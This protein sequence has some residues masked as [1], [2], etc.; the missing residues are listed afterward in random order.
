[1]TTLRD[2]PEIAALGRRASGADSA[3]DRRAAHAARA[4]A[5]RH[6][7]VSPAARDQPAG[8]GV[9]RLSGGQSHAVRALAGR[10]S[11]GAVVSSTG[12][13]TTSGSPRR[14]RRG[15]PSG[16]WW[17][18]CCTTWGTGRS[19]IRSK[20][21][22]CRR[23]PTHELFA[24]S[25]LLEGEIADAAARRL[26]PPAARR[27]RAALRQARDRSGRIL[28]SM[29][30]GPIDVDKMDY[31]M[32][33][34]LH[35]GVPYGRNFDQPRLIDSLCLNEAGD[36]AGDHRQGQDGRR[37][38]GL[39]PLRDVQRSLLASRRAVGHGDAAAGVFAR[40]TIARSRRPVSPDR[41][42]D[43]RR[44]ARRGGRRP[45]RRTARRTVRPDAAALQAGRPVQLVPTAG[46]LPAAGPPAVSVAGS[47]RRA[48]RDASASTALARVVAP[49]EILFDAPPVELEVEFQIDVFFP[50][51]NCYRR[52]GDVSPV[53]QTLAR[54]Q[55][56]DYVKRVRIFA[57]PRIADDLRST[58]P[59][60]RPHRRSRRH[61]G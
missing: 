41:A 49:H 3:G 56:D 11:H 43:D 5:H 38:D 25:F 44:D 10:V 23:F 54:E 19:A 12:S 42:A 52:L 39:C 59:T 16:S 28:R 60:P 48:L 55:F 14:S 6:A 53:V 2:L 51:E 36:G 33:D 50:K 47:L 58:G 1:M 21:C 26:G 13:P 18:R 35:A 31:L 40:C 57:H 7:R 20:T 61:A 27:R 45:G 15:R 30:S 29:L 32:R 22:A 37:D 46:A 34:S 17:P 24:N 8:A 9:P 4:A